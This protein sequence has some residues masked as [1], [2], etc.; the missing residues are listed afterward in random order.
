MQL[1]FVLEPIMCLVASKNSLGQELKLYLA[2]KTMRMEV[3]EFF[4]V[5]SLP[6]IRTSKSVACLRIDPF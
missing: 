3:R 5:L 2:E 1:Q 4:L 6:P